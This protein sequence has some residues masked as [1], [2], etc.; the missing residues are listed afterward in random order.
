MSKVFSVEPPALSPQG[1][2]N[3]KRRWRRVRRIVALPFAPL[4]LAG[5]TVPTFGALPGATT[6]SRSPYHLWQGF[7]I[8]AVI[9]GGFTTLLILWVVFKYRS[10]SDRIPKQSQYHIP[11]EMPYTVVPVIIVLGLFA[12]TMVV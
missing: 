1:V 7:S 3:R 6:S 5:C 2:S 9:V 10:Q 11:L 4:A 8:G 12:A